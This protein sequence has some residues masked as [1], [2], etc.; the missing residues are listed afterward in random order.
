MR[1]L[2]LNKMKQIK[3]FSKTTTSKIGRDVCNAS[4]SSGVAEV[5]V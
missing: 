2:G 1:S 5:E 4:H 3:Q